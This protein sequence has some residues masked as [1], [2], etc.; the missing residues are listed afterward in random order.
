MRK[1]GKWRKIWQSTNSSWQYE[2]EEK[3]AIEEIKELEL[4]VDNQQHNIK[5]LLEQCDIQEE[6]KDQAS[7]SAR[8]PMKIIKLGIWVQHVITDLKKLLKKYT[9]E[10]HIELWCNYR[11]NIFRNI[12]V[13]D[14]HMDD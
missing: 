6:D 5:Q 11:G 14:N 7:I 3:M 13:V 2:S 12:N 4:K 9:Q 1:I 8:T 10:N